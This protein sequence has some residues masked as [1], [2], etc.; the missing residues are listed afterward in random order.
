MRAVA[1]LL[2]FIQASLAVVEAANET[3]NLH[4]GITFEALSSSKHSESH[5]MLALDQTASDT[6]SGGPLNVLVRISSCFTVEEAT[7]VD[8]W[9]KDQLAAESSKL[10]VAG[11][12]IGFAYTAGVEPADGNG[13]ILTWSEVPAT[14]MPAALD[15]II[16]EAVFSISKGTGKLSALSLTPANHFELRVGGTAVGAE[17]SFTSVEA[18][19]SSNID[20]SIYKVPCASI[21][22]SVAVPYINADGAQCVCKCP[23]GTTL[24]NGHCDATPVS[25]PDSCTWGFG[26][27]GKC[28]WSTTVEK[29]TL[30]DG[31]GADILIPKDN[32]VNDQRVNKNDGTNPL[33]KPMIEITGGPSPKLFTWKDYVADP[34][35]SLNSVEFSD[36]GVYDLAVTASD[37]DSSAKCSGCLAVVDDF[38]PEFLDKFEQDTSSVSDSSDVPITVNSETL[39]KAI[40]EEKRFDDASKSTNFVNNAKTEVIHKIE[41][42]IEDSVGSHKTESSLTV[43]DD[44]CFDKDVVKHI[45]NSDTAKV[46]PEDFSSLSCHRSC[47]R[48]LTLQELVK[49]YS[50]ADPEGTDPVEVSMDGQTQTF[51]HFMQVDSSAFVTA[52]A[53]VS[54]GADTKSKAV[55]ESIA[56]ETFTPGTTFIHRVCPEGSSTCT[57]TETLGS[58][59]T[60]TSEWAATIPGEPDLPA[61][62]YS[63]SSYVFW[64][65]KVGGTG[66]WNDWDATKSIDFADST[67]DVSL[68]AYTV[69]GSI[70]APVTFRYELHVQNEVISCHSFPSMWQQVSTN[71]LSHST[72]FCAYPGSDFV[73]MFFEF[74]GKVASGTGVNPKFTGLHCTLKLG[75]TTAN[76]GASENTGVKIYDKSN[77]IDGQPIVK[78]FGVELINKPT[79]EAATLGH[80]ECTFDYSVVGTPGSKSCSSSFEFVDC[81]TP[82]LDSTKDVCEENKCKDTT[83]KAGPGEA[84]SGE[85][86]TYNAEQTS[87]KTPTGCCTDCSSTV[88]LSCANIV[89]IPGV[90]I[91]RCEPGTAATAGEVLADVEEDGVS[92]VSVVLVGATALVALVALVAVKRRGMATQE[93]KTADNDAYY[94]L[95]E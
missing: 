66:S 18:L 87:S 90:D 71:P 8:G 23:S 95:L 40:D 16:P 94:P 38:R 20:A 73:P 24:Q 35:V 53:K 78:Y 3:A 88:T 27:S 92:P 21:P 57:L 79:T 17:T 67:T 10:F 76:L 5:V 93:I 31:C 2:A 14:F 60:L 36:F 54:S 9:V 56:G 89:D 50:C 65:Y 59:F 43:T 83:G 84:C 68:Q 52:S 11:S 22:G 85:V 15:S 46:K 28:S 33:T 7:K 62:D 47:R 45:L 86:Y 58:L 82:E 72:G 6:C 32:Y 25:S 29:K 63:A 41:R 13:C 44:P 77:V 4:N 64:R 1:A 69:C 12:P 39:Q 30:A 48:T 61:A 51:S 91:S 34:K 70:S 49:E 19:A 55:L 75:D 42:T 26:N 74:S 81:S 37:Y 80:I